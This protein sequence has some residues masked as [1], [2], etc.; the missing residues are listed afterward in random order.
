[1]SL[2][3]R[4]PAQPGRRAP[5]PGAVLD[6]RR[7]L[8]GTLAVATTLMTCG[9]GEDEPP[10]RPER[11]TGPP[12]TRFRTGAVMTVTGIVAHVYGP[13]AFTLDDVDLPEQ[14]LLVLTALPQQLRVRDLATATGEVAAFTAVQFTDPALHS[15]LIQAG[16]AD[17]IVLRAND[18][19]LYRSAS[20]PGSHTPITARHDPGGPPSR[21]RRTTSSGGRAERSPP[22]VTDPNVIRRR[23]TS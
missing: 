22:S 10:P 14:G 15:R 4:H 11:R 8:V 16:H 6:R 2:R 18:V 1:M 9:C 5:F 13:T 3:T 12:R 23:T 19:V 7:L 17:A 20:A 21:L